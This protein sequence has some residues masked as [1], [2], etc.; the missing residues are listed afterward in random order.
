[1]EKLKE[2]ILG[3]AETQVKEIISK[4]EEEAKKIIGDAK[5]KAEMER[6]RRKE[7]LLKR[8]AE[9]E[10][11]TISLAR[12]EGKK[13]ILEVKESILNELY[14]K[15]RESL[16]AMDRDDKYLD[17]LSRL[18]VKAIK[19]IGSN[20]VFIQLNDRDREFLKK[21]WRKFI[22]KVSGELENVDIELMDGPINIMGGL[23]AYSEGGEKI[24]N[25][26]L[27]ARLEEIFRSERNVILTRLFGE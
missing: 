11:A 10:S 5:S 26:S 13:L 14:K 21:R 17:I 27:D 18:A 23:L 8:M 15:V 19:E 24:Y 22:N 25:N 12:I 20:K 1:M 9:K 6:N 16:E 7:A 2:E 4:A 3:D